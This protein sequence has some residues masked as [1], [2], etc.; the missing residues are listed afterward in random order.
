MREIIRG[1]SAGWASSVAPPRGCSR[2]GGMA[3]GSRSRQPLLPDATA[4]EVDDLPA[5]EGHWPASRPLCNA[6]AFW[7]NILDTGRSGRA[8]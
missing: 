5:L 3:D 1:L 6:I 8:A 7:T 2:H 4:A